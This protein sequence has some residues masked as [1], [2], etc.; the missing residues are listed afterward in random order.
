[1]AFDPSPFVDFRERLVGNVGRVIL[2][3]D[4]EI[5]RLLV[6]LVCRGHVLLDDVPGTGKTMLARAVAGSLGGTFRR[7]QFTPDLLPNDVTGVT[8]YNQK[9]GD[10]EL[11]EGPVFTNIL[12]ADEINRAT[13]RTQSALLEAMGETQVS[14]DGVTHTLPTPFMVLA[15]QNPVEFE[16][17]FPLPEAQLDRFMLRL[18]LGYP[19]F[20]DERRIL[21][22]QRHGHPIDSLE[23]VASL[24][25]LSA[26]QASVGTVHADETVIEFM[27]NV[28]RGTRGHADVEL[29]ASARGSL[30]LFKTSQA[31]A[32]LRGRDFVLPDDAKEMAPWVLPHRVLLKPESALRGVTAADL[33]NTLIGSTE[34]AIVTQDG[35]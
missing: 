16:G 20:D 19:N 15:T 13:P 2:G 25:E 30:A 31:L 34:L 32:A 9:T 11:R 3:K 33:V 35:D 27:L 23:P 29:G 22:D 24:E 26:L 10:F 18:T 28:A 5:E 17:T 14:I 8:V 12:L 4:A 7:V 1:M 6:A 21:D